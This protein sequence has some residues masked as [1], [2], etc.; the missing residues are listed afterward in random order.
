MDEPTIIDNNSI[1]SNTIISYL[2]YIS[3]QHTYWASFS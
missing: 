1:V 3:V 2:N